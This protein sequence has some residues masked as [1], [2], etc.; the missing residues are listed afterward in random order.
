VT[1]GGVKVKCVRNIVEVAKRKILDYGI[2][3]AFDV[4]GDYENSI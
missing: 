1:V 3:N 4:Q 2:S